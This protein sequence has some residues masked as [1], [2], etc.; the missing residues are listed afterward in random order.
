MEKQPQPNRLGQMVEDCYQRFINTETGSFTRDD[1]VE[2]NFVYTPIHAVGDVVRAAGDSFLV[3]KELT[4]HTRV[5]PGVTTWKIGEFIDDYDPK[6][7]ENFWKSIS[8]YVLY[9]ELSK[10]HPDID[11]MMERRRAKYPNL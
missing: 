11:L 3:M 4:D 9:G 1:G 10:R 8:E 5:V 2:I 7:W 6:G